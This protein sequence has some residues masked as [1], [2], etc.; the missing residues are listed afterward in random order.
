MLLKR[1]LEVFLVVCCQRELCARGSL[2]DALSFSASCQSLCKGPCRDSGMRLVVEN[3]CE[4]VVIL[5]K[6]CSPSNEKNAANPGR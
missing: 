5:L 3:L 6:C 1:T 4:R 2:R